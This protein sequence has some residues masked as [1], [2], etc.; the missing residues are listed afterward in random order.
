MNRR[1][2][3]LFY[4]VLVWLLAG[5]APTVSAADAP[6][7]FIIILTEDLGY[8]DVGF[9]GSK[10]IP[11]PNLDS[12]ASNG[13]KFTS[14]YAAEGLS[15]ASRA[16]LLTGQYPGRFGYYAE[17]AW[18]PNNVKDG[19]PL[20]QVTL[21]EVLNQAGY[22]C[23][24]IGKW[25]LGAHADLHPLKRGFDEFFGFLGPGASY[26]PEGLTNDSPAKI[27]AEY[28]AYHLR[29]LRN[30]VSVTVTNYL[31]DEFSDEAVRFIAKNKAKP[32]FLYLAYHAPHTPWE[33]PE[34]YLNRF[35]DLQSPH[36]KTYAAMVSAVDDG[37][38]RVLAEL[39]KAG[40]ENQTLVVF[41]S[42]TGGSL[43]QNSSDNYPLRGV[44]FYGWEGGWRVPFVMQW[45]GHLPAG[46]V[47]DQPVVSLDIFATFTALAGSP[48]MRAPSPDGVN[49]IPYLTGTKTDP[50]HDAL[51]LNLPQRGIFAVRSGDYKLII[52]GPNQPA[53]LFNLKKDVAE[54]RNVADQQPGIL[55]ELAQKQA[56]WTQS[57]A[58]AM[59]PGTNAK[60]FPPEE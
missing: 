50:P 44:K 17:S 4:G 34:K 42:A 10:D 54:T 27:K 9:N 31:T 60:D 12:I 59:A 37:V 49:L 6:P 13:V 2:I 24:I 8:H 23:G 26:F 14:G 55:A 32:F 29:I 40:L 46:M 36:R 53:Q 56:V 7:N 33:A 25:G 58:N 51:Y 41:L 39:R 52:P 15:A 11:T 3:Q 38:G 30:N 1:L 28:E 16:G 18:Q 45:P 35:P 19:L 20:N 5:M 22:H 47:Y 21:A 43:D 57:L 48:F